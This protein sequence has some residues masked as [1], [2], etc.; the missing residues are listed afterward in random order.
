M[1][2]IPSRNESHPG[3]IPS[4]RLS[5]L[6]N[7]HFP[8]LLPNVLKTNKEPL[9]FQYADMHG[10]LLERL[11]SARLFL[12]FA[13]RPGKIFRAS[14]PRSVGDNAMGSS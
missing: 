14:S 4:Q 7:S 3:Y 5:K 9:T 10:I 8:L 2:C 1:H 12:S 13:Q 6:I 11:T